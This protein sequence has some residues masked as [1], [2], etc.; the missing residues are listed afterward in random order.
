MHHRS[1][2]FLHTVAA[3]SLAVGFSLPLAAPLRADEARVA[4]LL[5]QLREAEGPMAA[6]IATEILTEWSKSGSPAIDLL[7]RRGEDA[8]EAGDPQAAIEHFTAAIDHDPDFT[9][10]YYDRATAYYATGNIG[11]ALDDLR[12]V[13]A[14]NPDHFQALPLFA[15]IIAE[16]GREEDALEVFERTLEIYPADEQA[17]L[18]AETLARDLEGQVL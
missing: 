7:L 11:P 13:L 6:R 2:P 15:V 16:M 3:L 9:A 8:M 18:Y 5:G 10:A 1:H 17:A 12:E 14:R 4:D